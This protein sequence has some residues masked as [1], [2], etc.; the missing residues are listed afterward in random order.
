MRTDEL[1][2]LLAVLRAAGVSEFSDVKRGVSVKLGGPTVA[3]ASKA[4]PER[5]PPS[6]Q[7][8]MLASKPAQTALKNLGVDAAAAVEV[9][10]DVS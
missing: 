9:L 8:Q 3:P 5:E 4:K 2:S 6:L 7:E 1:K 10:A